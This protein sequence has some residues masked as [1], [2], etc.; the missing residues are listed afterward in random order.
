MV[1]RWP[2]NPNAGPFAL[3]MPYIVKPI[4][5]RLKGIQEGCLAISG[6]AAEH[7]P[8]L[9]IVADQECRQPFDIGFG[10]LVLDEPA[11]AVFDFRLI[12]C[13]QNVRCLLQA[14]RPLKISP[15]SLPGE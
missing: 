7:Y 5:R 8:E 11:V 13:Q 4:H 12:C 15:R 14:H 1:I 9:G 2:E 6:Y 10:R 3:E